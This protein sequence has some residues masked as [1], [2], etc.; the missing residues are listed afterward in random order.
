MSQNPYGPPQAQPLGTNVGNSSGSVPANNP[1]MVPAIILIVLSSLWLAYAVF[2]VFFV[3]MDGPPPV[4]QG[5]GPEFEMGQKVGFYGAAFMLPVL[6]LIT[7]IGSIQML[8]LR[9]FP[10]CLTAAIA[11]LVP[12]CGPCFGLSLPF[13]IWA[14]VLLFNPDVKRR[15][16]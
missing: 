14:L 1:L 10:L 12:V 6:S 16:R 9:T 5:Q 13:G 11:S 3:L 4:P 7:L 8:R 15:F 2:N